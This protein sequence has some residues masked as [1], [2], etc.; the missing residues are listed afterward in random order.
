M[1][2]F[3]KHSSIFI[4]AVLL[5][6]TMGCTKEGTGG[7]ASVSGNVKHHQELIPNAMVYIKYGATE[8]PGADVSVYDDKVTADANSHYEFKD[9]EKGDYYLYSI[10]MDGSDIVKG[11]IGVVLLRKTHTDSDIPVTE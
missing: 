11:G 1:K 2:N 8:F 6:V 9:L 3:T 10:G 4:F 5:F 7:K